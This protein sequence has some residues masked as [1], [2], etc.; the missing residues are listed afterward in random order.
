MLGGIE[1]QEKEIGYISNYYKKISVAAVEM[2]DGPVSV[3][4]NLHIKGHTTDLELK[5]DS[6]EIEHEAVMEAKQ[7]DS[8]GLKVPEKVR[9]KD[10]VYKIID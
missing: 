3:N 4:D 10:K 2:T 9:R 6:M 1:V 8:I 5:V 7:G